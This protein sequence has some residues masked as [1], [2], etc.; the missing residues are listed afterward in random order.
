MSIFSRLFAQRPRAQ[1]LSETAIDAFA[2]SRSGEVLIQAYLPTTSGLQ[3]ASGPVYVAPH[4]DLHVIGK[5]LRGALSLPYE[6]LPHPPQNEWPLVQKPMLAA[7]NVRSWKALA[8]GSKAVS[9]SLNGTQLELTPT[10]YYEQAGG[11]SLAEAAVHADLTD[12][13]LAASLLEA[14]ARC[15]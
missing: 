6:V 12:P 1:R 15:R 8:K 11:T 14:F 2:L 5:A 4:D 3:I 7:A 9:V 13:G 10:E